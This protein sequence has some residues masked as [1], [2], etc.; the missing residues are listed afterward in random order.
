M[1]HVC[2]PG[3]PMCY[4]NVRGRANYKHHRGYRAPRLKEAV[5]VAEFLRKTMA[6]TN[7][8]PVGKQW[9][10]DAFKRDYPALAEYLGLTAWE[11]G[12]AR[13]PCSLL[14]FKG[15]GRLKG[16]LRDREAG[17]VAFLTAG[18]LFELLEAFEAALVR[19]ELDWRKDR[20]S[21]AA[22]G[23]KRGG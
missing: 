15:D 3:C 17:Q 10:D 13:E 1:S 8:T 6:S 4:A 7:G 18:N 16:M 9:P 11:D 12:T 2:P 20:G 19:S 21:A 14:L 5:H 22:G 23:R